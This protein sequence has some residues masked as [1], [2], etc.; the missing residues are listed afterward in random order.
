M[1]IGKFK[2]AGFFVFTALVLSAGVICAESA[3][4]KTT[5]QESV[6]AVGVESKKPDIYK[7]LN[8]T[9]AQKK[10]L[11]ASRNKYREEMKKALGEVRVKKAAMYQELYKE[12]LD[13]NKIKRINNDL[14]KLEAQVLD[15]RLQ[16]VLDLRKILSPEQFSKLNARVANI[17]ENRRKGK[18]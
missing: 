2:I 13:A 16:S 9:E 7:D 4:D 11:D 1:N 12:K 14:K 3:V 17:M 5:V 8:L 18:K 6:A 10:A 15:Y